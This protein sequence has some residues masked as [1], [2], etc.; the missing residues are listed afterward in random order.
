M[1]SEPPMTEDGF[2]NRRAFMKWVAAAPLLGQI[3]ARELYAKAASVVGKDAHDNVYKRLGIKTIIN[4]RGSWTYLSG[5]LQLPEV[6]AA[7]L[8]AAR[9]FVNIFELQRAAGRKL[10][11]MKG[12]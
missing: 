11:E 5:S 9:H 1:W 4:C 7:Q 2:L 3:A 8:E 12:A 6:R 10:A